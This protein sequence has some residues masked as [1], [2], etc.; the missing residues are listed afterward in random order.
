MVW[1]DTNKVGCGYASGP[2]VTHVVC[3]Y[4]PAGNTFTASKLRDNV[5]AISSSSSCADQD[6]CNFMQC[7]GAFAAMAREMCPKKCGVC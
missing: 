3:R 4:N 5:K 1:R 7:D 6:G 2:T